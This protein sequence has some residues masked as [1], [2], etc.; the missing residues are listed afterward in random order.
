MRAEEVPGP[1]TSVTQL[2]S[3]D[4]CYTEL[5]DTLET[6]VLLTLDCL[7]LSRAMLE[8]A[9]PGADPD[10]LERIRRKRLARQLEA[11]IGDG[12]WPP[13]GGGTQAG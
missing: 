13:L 12:S 3:D 11:V 10:H 9:P 5:Q 1:Q 6:F 7:A 4:P 8:G 2:A